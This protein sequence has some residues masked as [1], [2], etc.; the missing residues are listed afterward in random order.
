[1]YERSVDDECAALISACN[2]L[3]A[4]LYIVLYSYVTFYIGVDISILSC[5][6]D[7]PNQE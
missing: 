2:V 7:M 4:M 3:R 5:S 6:Y 1:M